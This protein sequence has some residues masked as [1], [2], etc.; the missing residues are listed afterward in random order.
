MKGVAIRW[1]SAVQRT[2]RET[3]LWMMNLF[4]WLDN[5]P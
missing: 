3:L 4:L 2:E 1:D 5:Q